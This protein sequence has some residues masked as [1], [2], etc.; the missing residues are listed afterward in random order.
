MK[1]VN[2]PGSSERYFSA[3]VCRPMTETRLGLMLVS[4]LIVCMLVLL[5]FRLFSM[6][7]ALLF[8]PFLFRVFS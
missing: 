3:L 7:N 5:F 4:S 2:T 1:R 8:D 6:L